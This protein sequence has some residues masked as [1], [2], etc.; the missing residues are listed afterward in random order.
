MILT[1]LLKLLNVSCQT[2]D[3]LVTLIDRLLRAPDVVIKSSLCKEP[4]TRQSVCLGMCMTDSD[5]AK[6][7]GMHKIADSKSA[8][9][10]TSSATYQRE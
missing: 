3:T 1:Q 9:S 5:I 4:L 6:H 10:C 7:A 8:Y 2:I